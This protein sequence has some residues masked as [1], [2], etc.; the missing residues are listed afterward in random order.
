MSRRVDYVCPLCHETIEAPRSL[1]GTA[2]TCPECER[3]V[4]CWP[5]PV[6]PPEPPASWADKHLKSVGGWWGASAIALA[7]AGIV[8]INV[9]VR[10]GTGTVVC[11]PKTTG[12]TLTCEVT[13]KGDRTYD[14]QFVPH[15]M[16]IYLRQGEN[17]DRLYRGVRLTCVVTVESG[18]AGGVKSG[19]RY[20]LHGTVT[21]MDDGE[22]SLT[23]CVFD[24]VD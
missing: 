4:D 9:V 15:N 20:R 23:N 6:E 13:G 21:R 5:A 16:G 7:V 1:E 17:L 24:P 19:G 10:W 8:I 22:V 3:P 2:A 12:W 14:E 18:S 11:Y